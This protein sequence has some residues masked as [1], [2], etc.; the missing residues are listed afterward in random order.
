MQWVSDLCRRE[1]D[2]AWLDYQEWIGLRHTPVGN[3]KTE[4][5][6]APLHGQPR[7]DKAAGDPAVD[8][9]LRNEQ[10]PSTDMMLADRWQSRCNKCAWN[11]FEQ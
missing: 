8:A 10:G 5:G 3:N 11:L 7:R 2:Q 1:L 4:E 9:G 6:Q